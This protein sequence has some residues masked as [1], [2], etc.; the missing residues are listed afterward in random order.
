M[1]ATFVIPCFNEAK[2][3]DPRAIAELVADPRV[4]VVLVDDG[5]TDDT[6]ALLRG[7]ASERVRVLALE[8]NSGKAEAV[9]R[10]LQQ[11]IAEGA[12]V[13]GFADADFATPVSELLR[14][15]DELEQSGK[16]LVLG[17]R[18]LRLGA[19]IDRKPLRHLV[20]RVFATVAAAAVGVPVYDTQCGAKLFRVSPRL[21]W[22][23]ESPFSSRWSF[24]VELLCRLFGR[25][26]EGAPEDE[27]SALEV[28]LHVWHEVGGSKL[29]LGS[30]AR[31]F[32]E[33]LRIWARAEYR[34]RRR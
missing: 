11:A 23:L 28:P 27:P 31:S 8:R 22:A 14:L 21:S 16:D 5:S 34:A 1:G 9:R 13:V 7:L 4:S 17:S 3:L 20:G 10:G 25:L 18:V 30:M 12:D 33:L 6:L 29:H 15:L 32:A 2:R 26:G 24:D 19:S